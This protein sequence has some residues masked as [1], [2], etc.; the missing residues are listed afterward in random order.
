MFTYLMWAIGIYIVASYIWG[1]YVAWRLNKIRKQMNETIDAGV[2]EAELLA[3][4]EVM[5]SGSW[6]D[7]EDG[8]EEK[9]E[10]QSEAA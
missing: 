1:A 5:E 6:V 10:D 9:D 4:F 8:E 2:G 7:V 3:E